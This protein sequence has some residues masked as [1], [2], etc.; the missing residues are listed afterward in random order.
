MPSAS[1]RVQRSASNRILHIAVGP[2]LHQRPQLVHSPMPRRSTAQTTIQALRSCFVH[3]HVPPNAPRPPVS[4]LLLPC[5]VSPGGS[6]NV[7][8]RVIFT[9][10]ATD[11][12]TRT[13]TKGG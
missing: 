2:E 8:G 12:G 1:S 7:I 9:V 6:C 11:I 3:T 5:V 4:R 13:P 10:T